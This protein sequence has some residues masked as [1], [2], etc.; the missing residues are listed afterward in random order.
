[1]N[2][3]F[4]FRIAELLAALFTGSH[5][6]QDV[7]ELRNWIQENERRSKFTTKILNEDNFEYNEK[8]LAKFPSEERWQRVKVLLDKTGKSKKLRLWMV[9]YTAAVVLL[10][11]AVVSSLCKRN[12]RCPLDNRERQG[13]RHHAECPLAITRRRWHFD[14]DGFPRY[15]LRSLGFGG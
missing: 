3:K 6:E 11:V 14:H 13:D 9:R 7:G 2:D 15:G 12:D 8:M 1:M 5:S 4:N 10:L